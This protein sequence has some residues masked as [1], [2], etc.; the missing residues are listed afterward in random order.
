MIG[1]QDLPTELLGQIFQCLPVWTPA[2]GAQAAKTD[3]CHTN[4]QGLKSSSQV[5]KRVHSVVEP[6]LYHTFIRYGNRSRGVTQCLSIR[7]FIRTLLERPELRQYVKV[8]VIEA[9]GR[10][11]ETIHDANSCRRRD[12]RSLR[13]SH[14]LVASTTY[15]H[16]NHCFKLLLNELDNGSE[17]PEIAVLF[18]L[19]PSL[20]H[21]AMAYPSCPANSLATLGYYRSLV[22]ITLGYE[23]GRHVHDFPQLVRF[24][25]LDP[26]QTGVDLLVKLLQLPSLK[27]IDGYVNYL[28]P[29]LLNSLRGLFGITDGSSAITTVDLILRDRLLSEMEPAIVSICKGLERLSLTFCPS[30]YF[31][32]R[33]NRSDWAKL[34]TPLHNHRNTL[35]ALTL[36]AHISNRDRFRSGSAWE[37]YFDSTCLKSLQDMEVLTTLHLHQ[38]AIFA[39][40]MDDQS[41]S[42]LVD[43]LPASLQELVITDVSPRMVPLLN[44]LLRC[45]PQRFPDLLYIGLSP[46]FDDTYV[47]G[48]NT[49]W[50]PF[51]G[52]SGAEPGTRL[53]IVDW[54][55][56]Y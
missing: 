54:L 32:R 22:Q 23:R 15:M 29:A 9:L 34:N 2:D 42:H 51:E 35:K 33:S 56:A 10:N 14:L 6:F 19:T 31:C 11:S 38:S 55:D 48:H 17:T 49:R 40:S 12:R 5:S 30:A 39:S 36:D 26:T 18:F 50:P 41:E 1:L 37:Q 3:I 45:T 52:L 8:V 46:E 27:T 25:A 24:T 13:L 21:L 4:Y 20:E 43:L 7:R 44:A 28:S 16:R 47:V 53:D